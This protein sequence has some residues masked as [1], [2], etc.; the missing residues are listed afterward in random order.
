MNPLSEEQLAELAHRR[1]VVLVLRRRL[2]VLELQIAHQGTE[3]RPSLVL[4][5]DDLAAQIE[6]HESVIARLTTSTMTGSPAPHTSADPNTA[7]LSLTQTFASATTFMHHISERMEAATNSIDDVTWGTGD[8]SYS[9]D[10]EAAYHA[11]VAT[12]AR[13]CERG[14]RYRHVLAFQDRHYVD[15]V[16]TFL[17]RSLPSYHVRYYDFDHHGVPPLMHFVIIDERELACGFYRWPILAP[18][19]EVRL[20]TMDPDIVRLFLDYY[21]TLWIGA[22][23]LKEGNRVDQA[24]WATIKQS[25]QSE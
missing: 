2:R 13:V 25:W 10:E 1:E 5:R 21:E 23:H 15:R 18:F 19:H 3:A 12:A 8:P 7:Y 17:A 22:R 9:S 20:A 6:Q 4:E 14:I 24:A 11:L 16:E